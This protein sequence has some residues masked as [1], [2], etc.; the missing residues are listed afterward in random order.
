MEKAFLPINIGSFTLPNRFV[1]GSMHLGLE[2]KTGT[3]ER[4]AA[5]YG[6]RFEGGVGLIVTGG[7]GVN[8]E[9]RGSKHFFNIQNEEH[10]SELSKMNDLLNGKGI[11]CAQLF[12][13][14]RYAFDRNCVGPSAI[15]APINRYIPR[16]LTEEE[17]W[18]TAEDFG[19]A[20][21]LARETGFGAVE[22][23]GSEGYLI[24]Q[25]F[26]PVTNHRDDHFGGDPKR[27]MNMAVEVL[28]AVVKNLPEG[29]PII[30]RM[31]G[32][33]LIPGNPTFEEVCDLAQ[34]LKQEGVSALNIGIGWHESRIPTISQLVP[35]GAWAN[36]AGRIKEKTPGIPI[37]ASNRVNDPITAQRIFDKNQ[38]DIISMAR[39]FLADPFIVKKIQ[40]G[41]SNRI[42][43]CIACNQSCLDHAF[44]DKSVS[45]L[46]NPQAVNELEYKIDPAV[47]S[48][49]VV[50]IGSGPGGLEAAR[51]SASLGHKVILLEKADQ[52]GGQ[53]LLASNIPGKS[54]FK[55]TIRYF[56]NE[57]PA[58]GV[59]IR[60]NT[61]C[62]LKLLEE[63]DPD[64]IIFATG[65]KPREFT[66]PGINTLPVGNYTEYLTGKFKPGKKVAVIGGGGIGVDV[67]HKLTEENDP[68]LES[69]S[70]K[71]NIDSYTNTVIQP[72]KS[73]RDV[74]IFRRS[75]KHGAGLG[76]T[77]FWALKQELE[78][79]GVEFFQG[80]NY[81]EITK[82]GLKI[83]MKNGEEVLYPCDSLILCVGQEKES[84][85]YET[86]KSLYPQKQIFVIGGAK[87]SKGID[88]ERA[89]LEGLN[90]AYSIGKE[91]KVAA[92]V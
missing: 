47:K 54:E 29:F 18:K 39:P 58:L 14:G 79:S 15:R 32:I 9:A 72:H 40:S 66:L 11:M 42:N 81:K 19:I 86:Y 62:D 71:Y 75:G 85:L 57:L 5:F 21:K 44:V 68:D 36:I 88:A 53:F 74:A 69:Y 92:T 4:M 56:K 45:C 20:A 63:L 12:H 16:A 91:N 76:P 48:Q 82:D 50:V 33:D 30:F 65:V 67:A 7:I 2:G 43:T 55:E 73:E 78:A 10:A 46:V 59:D 89:F 34:T 26:S 80:L 31:S 60:L 8:E 61:N 25:F 49:K 70:K 87:D 64:S 77:T 52:L 22:I 41:M 24:N 35:R 51:A 37:I 6:K 28:R 90:A 38:A 83:T 1:M 3:A 27:R 23:M 13:A 84:S 17:C